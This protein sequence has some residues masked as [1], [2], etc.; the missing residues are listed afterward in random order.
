VPPRR[1]LDDVFANLNKV[2]EAPRSAESLSALQAALASPSSFAAA[3]AAHLAAELELGALGPDLVA[4]FDRFLA[5]D[6]DDPGCTAKAATAEAL[7]RLGH[8]GS[9]GVFLRGIRHVQ[10]EP[11]FGGRVDTAVDLRGACAFGLVRIGYRDA[12]VELADLLADPEAPVRISAA[13]ALAYRGGADGVP[14]LRLRVLTGDQPE[15]MGECL[16]ALLRLSGRG[17]LPFASRFLDSPKQEVAEAAAL[18]LG[19][20]RLE[21]AFADLREW[22]DRTLNAT[23]R[24][25]GLLAIASLRRDAGFEYLFGLVEQGPAGPAA[26]A[27]EALGM[28][29][30]EPALAERLRQAA[31][32]REEAAVRK[33]LRRLQPDPQ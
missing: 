13:R 7:Y 18:A 11:V 16:Q 31:S 27:I 28:Y 5:G 26:Q 6:A 17:A 30:D 14:L 8:E 9:A 23:L 15:V 29:K 3:K 32:G 2:R 24:R 25:A 21:E 33:A 20:S 10:M 19:A 22:V 4:A 12:L 1:K